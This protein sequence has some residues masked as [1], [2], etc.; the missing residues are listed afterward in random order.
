MR[1]PC[2]KVPLALLIV[3]LWLAAC[4]GGAGT[5][6]AGTNATLSPAATGT[7]SSRTTT[8]PQATAIQHSFAY[9]A[10]D[11]SNTVSAYSISPATG[12]LAPVGSVTA[13]IYPTQVAVHPSGKFAYASNTSYQGVSAYRIDAATGA[14]TQIGATGDDSINGTSSVAVD[15]GGNFLFVPNNYPS[16]SPFPPP[17]QPQSI[18]T[19]RIDADTGALILASTVVIGRVITAIEVPRNGNVAYVKSEGPNFIAAFAIDPASGALT[20][21]AATADGVGVGRIA[22]HPSG[23]FAY[24]ASSA[25]SGPGEVSTYQLD[26]AVGTLTRQGSPVTTGV[27]PQSIAVHPDGNLAYVANQNSNDIWIYRIDAA[28]GALTPSG[29][30]VSAGNPK[31]IA[32]DPSGQFAYIGMTSGIQAY[33]VDAATGALTAVATPVQRS[34]LAVSIAT[35]RTTE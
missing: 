1:L 33:S 25:G 13:G 15:P 6:T 31:S 23:K 9:V 18:S 27:V 19:W 29:A 32:F 4:G 16:D 2:W 8:L 17:Q 14:L 10:D 26:P 35:T 7:P 21:I 34:R 12:E 22:A 3:P 11:F 24:A 5:D 20:L 30:P 28:S